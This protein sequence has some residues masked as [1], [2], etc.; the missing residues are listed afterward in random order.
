MFPPFAETHSLYPN[1]TISYNP[2]NDTA[3]GPN[4]TGLII[5]HPATMYMSA[6]LTPTLPVFRPQ[7]L[8]YNNFDNTT[9]AEW[10]VLGKHNLA[11]SAPFTLEVLEE[12]DEDDGI[13]RHGPLRMSNVPSLEGDT[14][15]RNFTVLDG[16]KGLRLRLKGDEDDKKMVLFWKRLA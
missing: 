12:E 10:A 15:V 16:G 7:N 14:L 1:G 6:M 5:Y 8:E 4:G 13:L 11:Y 3:Q 9:D 2:R